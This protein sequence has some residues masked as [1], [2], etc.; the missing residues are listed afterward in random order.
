MQVTSSYGVEI[1]RVNSSISLTYRIY[2]EA[3]RVLAVFYD[4]VWEDLSAVE[5]EKKRF[6]HAEHLVHETKKNHAVYDF[7][8]RFPKMPSYLRRSAIMHALGAV[9]SYRT[10]LAG[11]ERGGRKGK[12]PVL[13]ERTHAMPVFYRGNMYREKEGDFAEIKLFNGRDWVWETASLLHT[14]MEY[15]RKHWTGVKASAPTLEKRHRKYFLRFSYTEKKE[16]GRKPVQE[17]RICAVDLGINTDA[18]CSIMGSDGTVFARMFVDFADEKDRLKKTLNRI[19]RKNREHGPKSAGGLWGYAVRCN[20][21]LSRKTAAEIVRFA[22]ENH[23]DVIVFEHLEMRGKIRGR[24]KMRLHLWKK[25]RVREICEHMAHRKGMRVSGVCAWKTS[26]LAYDG[27]GKVER[28]PDNHSLCTFTNGKRYNCDLSASYNI[29][30]RYFI[31][32]LIK[33]LPATAGSVLEAKVPAVRRRSSCVYADLV[34]LH[35]VM[36]ENG[37]SA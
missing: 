4:T 23:A 24:R 25:R 6:N 10:R 13:G 20:E 12:R 32:E 7:D 5:G 26:A 16:L 15:L 27:S 2:R 22:E 17:Q 29:G 28:D 31:R 14:D 8:S 9:S 11:W 37:W 34:R 19:R 33:P 30:A 3:V 1:R 18:V 21:E 35:A 36:R